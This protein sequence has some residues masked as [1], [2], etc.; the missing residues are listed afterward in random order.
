MKREARELLQVAKELCGDF[1][2]NPGTLGDQEDELEKIREEAE[3]K[4]AR[5]CE[6]VEGRYYWSPGKS[7]MMNMTLTG[8]PLMHVYSL[9]GLGGASIDRGSLMLNPSWVSQR[10]DAMPSYKWG[11]YVD[12]IIS[13]IKGSEGIKDK[14]E[15]DL[16]EVERAYGEKIPTS[17]RSEAVNWCVKVSKGRLGVK[18]YPGPRGK[19]FDLKERGLYE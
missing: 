19:F 10:E 11:F 1:V 15:K 7:V 17:V 8:R 3:A 18:S 6:V 13:M 12:K 4:L 5:E 14:I 16:N 2:D 9:R